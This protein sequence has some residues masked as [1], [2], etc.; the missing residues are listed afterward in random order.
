MPW[1]AQGTRTAAA[2]RGLPKELLPVAGK[3]LLEWTLAEAAAA[4][5]TRAVVVSSPDKA[6]ALEAHVTARP[7][8]G[9]SAVVVLQPQPRG[10]G[11]A[12]TCARAA[13][14]TDDVA[15]PLPDNLFAR[16]PAT[17]PAPDP[18]RPPRPAAP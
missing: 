16:G 2:A 9:L 10:L 6:P 13:V 11:D 14:G 3:P 1:R 12:I 17:L 18:P 4:G 8:A 15:L 7:P 5:L